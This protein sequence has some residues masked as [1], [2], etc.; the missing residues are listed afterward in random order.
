MLV[1]VYGGSRRPDVLKKRDKL[2]RGIQR[3]KEVLGGK[4]SHLPSQW[5]G[6]AL[7]PFF[8]ETIEDVDT[9]TIVSGEAALKL[10]G[11]LRQVA[12]AMDEPPARSD[13][14]SDKENRSRAARRA[15]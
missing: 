7:A 13:D 6:V 9:V 14:A 5:R 12:F 4:S 11:G 2:V 10:L 8:T 15:A 1:D 3:I